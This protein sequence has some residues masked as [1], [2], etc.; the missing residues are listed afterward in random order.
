MT[1][2]KDRSVYEA[3]LAELRKRLPDAAISEFPGFAGARYAVRVETIDDLDEWERAMDVT[4]DLA[5]EW[6]ERYGV[7]IRGSFDTKH[8]AAKAS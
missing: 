6:R 2:R 7:S 1:M 3:F 5:T 8:E 4:T